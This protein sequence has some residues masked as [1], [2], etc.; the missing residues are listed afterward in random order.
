MTASCLVELKLFGLAMPA[1]TAFSKCHNCCNVTSSRGSRE[2]RAHR[3]ACTR[4]HLYLLHFF[5]ISAFLEHFAK[6]ELLVRTSASSGCQLWGWHR[7]FNLLHTQLRA[8]WSQEEEDLGVSTADAARRP[9]VK[10]ST[11]SS[12]NLFRILALL[13]NRDR[14]TPAHYHFFKSYPPGLKSEHD[15]KPACLW[16]LAFK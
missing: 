8:V 16:A 5:F 9:S 2:V 7:S 11:S 1:S 4:P 10:S 15:N 13:V 3:R 6:N 14:S 12:S